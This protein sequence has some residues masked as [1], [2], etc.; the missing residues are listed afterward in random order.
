VFREQLRQAVRECGEPVQSWSA[1]GNT[2]SVVTAPERSL[3]GMELGPTLDAFAIELRGLGE[4]LQSA[5]DGLAQVVR[6]QERQRARRE[7]RAAVVP[8]VSY[9]P[10]L[11]SEQE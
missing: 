7:Q 3:D 10:F 9:V 4:D 2:E 6:F 5:V 1:A 11:F 8:G